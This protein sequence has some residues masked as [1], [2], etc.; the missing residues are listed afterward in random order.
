M[1]QAGHDEEIWTCGFEIGRGGLGF[2]EKAMFS[3]PVN[4]SVEGVGM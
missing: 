3:W 1:Q 2:R 4:K